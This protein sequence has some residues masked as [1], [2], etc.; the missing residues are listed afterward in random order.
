MTLIKFDRVEA[1]EGEIWLKPEDVNR[2][3]KAPYRRNAARIY[4]YVA[5]GEEY[6]D[7]TM[8][9]AEAAAIVLAGLES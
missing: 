3:V 8:T 1:S 6:A 5:G 4:H 9:T 2:I 7:V